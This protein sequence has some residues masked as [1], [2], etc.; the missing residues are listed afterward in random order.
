MKVVK[1]IS[2]YIGLW[3]CLVMPVS[4]SLPNAVNGVPM[5]SLADMLE[6]TTPAVVNISIQ[7]VETKEGLLD[8]F[9]QS[10]QA[11][12]SNGS[13]SGVIIDAA[14]G[15]IVTNHHV[16]ADANKVLVTLN[17]GRQYSA[18]IVGR[19]PQADIA[20][21]RIEADGLK[22]L[23]LGNS[24]RL[25][26]GDFVV[27]IGNPYGL[28]QSVTSGIIS[29]LGRSNLGI[30]DYEDFIQT[31]ASINPGN[32]GGA[33]VNLRGELIG[34]NTAIL[35]GGGGGNVGIGFAI[36]VN[37]VRN[38]I[39]QLI[40]HGKVERGQ[41]GVR[42]R[43]LDMQEARQL[44]VSQKRGAMIA[45]VIYGSPADLAGL[46][47][48]DVIV[49]VNQ[50]QVRSATDVRNKIGGL[51]RGTR[52]SLRVL[53]DGQPRDYMAVVGKINHEAMREPEPAPQSSGAPVWENAE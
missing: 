7:G 8:L 27:A 48:G 37:M 36:P 13:G 2:L 20:V 41:L 9:G 17:D 43:N 21:I 51:R 14:K 38:I 40:Q 5:P 19:D 46:K 31:D 35:G 50:R 22:Q 52:V 3:L 47:S 23:A 32:S 6:R 4:A 16:V 1:Y 18:D 34:I 15:H 10:M 26:V 30:E 25:R 24:D 33:L 28:G 42:V 11:R 39:N 12:P 45:E 49:S 53:R 29:A 44:G